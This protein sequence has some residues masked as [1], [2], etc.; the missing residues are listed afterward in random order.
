MELTYE[1]IKYCL[2][3]LIH[4]LS[5]YAGKVYIIGLRVLGFKVTQKK[6]KNVSLNCAA[7]FNTNLSFCSIIITSVSINFLKLYFHVQVIGMVTRKDLARYRTWKHQGRMGVEELLISKDMQT[8]I[9]QFK[10]NFLFILK[11]DSIFV[12]KIILLYVY[13]TKIYKVLY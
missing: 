5:K 12:L 3:L 9:L 7:Q 6:S 2:L 4:G 1:F 8:Q 10:I 13:V 11:E